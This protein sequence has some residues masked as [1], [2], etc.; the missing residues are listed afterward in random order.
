M[1]RSIGDL[2]LALRVIAGA[3]SGFFEVPP[4]PLGEADAPPLEKLHVAWTNRFGHVPVTKDTERVLAGVIEQLAKCGCTVSK[5]MPEGFKFPELWEVFGAWYWAEVGAEHTPDEDAA[6][7][8]EAGFTPDSDDAFSR[9]AGR[10]VHAS[11]RLY[12]EIFAQRDH[13]I[14]A[15]DHLLDDWDVFICPVAATP[16]IPH[17]P[18]MSNVTVAGQVIN[19]FECGTYCCIPFNLTGHPVVV[20]PAGYADDGL[21]IGVQLVGRRWGEMRLLAIARQIDSIVG[22]YRRPPGC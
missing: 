20:I 3:D 10:A 8:E 11:M 15:F 5:Q 16:A 1:T 21:P 7:A 6:I 4:V 12:H 17:I 9:G 18:H 14:A 13:Y 22:A 19:Y 2:E